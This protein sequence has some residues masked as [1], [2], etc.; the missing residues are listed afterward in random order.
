MTKRKLGDNDGGDIRERVV[1]RSFS[2]RNLPSA[3][4]FARLAGVAGPL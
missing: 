4:H 3:I 2:R 1:F